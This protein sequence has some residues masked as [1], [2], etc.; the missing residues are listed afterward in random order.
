[1]KKILFSL[2]CILTFVGIVNAETKIQYDWGKYLSFWEFRSS[3]M[4]NGELALFGY[5]PDDFYYEL[6]NKNGETTLNKILE[7][8]DFTIVNDALVSFYYNSSENRMY[9]KIYD[10]D[11]NFIKE[12]YFDGHIAYSDSIT[13]V[14]DKYYFIGNTIFDRE[15]YEEINIG[16]FVYNHELAD[17]F[18]QVYET[19]NDLLINEMLFD[20][21]KDEFEGTALVV[22]YFFYS[23]YS[24]KYNLKDF[25][26]DENGNLVILFYD[27]QNGQYYISVYDKDYELLYEID[28]YSENQPYVFLENNKMYF[29]EYR[30][31]S[32]RTTSN[33]EY[34]YDVVLNEFDLEGKFI[35]EFVLTSI[36][37][38]DENNGLDDRGLFDVIKTNDGFYLLTDKP[39]KPPCAMDST[40]N[41]GDV[42][43]DVYPS[44]QKFSFVYNVET[45]ES[46]NGTIKVDKDSSKNG[47]KI[48]YTVEP[49]EGYK[50]DKVIV[51]DENGN[52]VIITDSSFTMP[53]SN[54]TIE[55]IFVVE[56]PN[57]SVFIRIGIFGLIMLLTYYFVI[58]QNIKVRKFE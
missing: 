46:E 53:N 13:G 4:I 19:G 21:C 20:I 47:D 31:T 17:E 9:Q 29:I 14:T 38:V 56:N 35:D 40:L 1:M 22:Y 2:I 41:E 42:I 28:V 3:G 36:V 51:T 7:D 44:I 58:L 24:S 27:N 34:H 25:S 37:D 32:E 50:L 52:Q 54:V 11:L 15:T 18:S 55:A 39:N 48:T 57:T 30:N 49:K 8:F 45:K 16:D 33:E 6:Y 12:V 10:K 23:Q 43:S 5:G 26:Y